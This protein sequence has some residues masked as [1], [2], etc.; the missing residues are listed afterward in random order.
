MC[1]LTTGKVDM[2][3]CSQLLQEQREQLAK[4]MRLAEEAH[5]G[6]YGKWSKWKESSGREFDL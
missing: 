2:Y 5:T 4:K 6:E 1:A 3:S